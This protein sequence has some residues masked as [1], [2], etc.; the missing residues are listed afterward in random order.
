MSKIYPR[1]SFDLSSFSPARKLYSILGIHE[2]DGFGTLYQ[3]R[4]G[5]VTLCIISLNVIVSL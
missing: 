5:G 2:V 4:F 1:S 3:I